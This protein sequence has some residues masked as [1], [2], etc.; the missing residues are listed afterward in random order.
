MS[1]YTPIAT[2]TLGSTASSVIFSSIPQGYTDLVIVTQIKATADTYLNLRFNEDTGSNYSRTT[3]SGSGSTVTSERRSSQSA[4]N[5][6]F[7]ENIQTNLNYTNTLQINNYSNST[8]FKTVICRA[9]NAASGAGA[10]IGLWRNTAAITSISLVANSQL[11]DSGSTFS[12]YGIQAGNRLAKADGGTTVTTD[13]TYWYHTF[14]SSGAFIPKQA[15]TNVDYLVVAGG[16]GGSGANGGADAGNGGGGAGGLRSTITQTGGNSAGVNL[17][18]KLSLSSGVSY[19]VIIGA[20][21]VGGQ[22]GNN[23]TDGTK[24]F[25]SIFSTITSIGGSGGNDYGGSATATGGSGGGAGAGAANRSLGT[26]NQGFDGGTSSGNSG[27][28]GGGAGAVGS[29]AS[30]STGGNGGAGISLAISGSSV[31]YAGGGGGGGKSTGG[32]GGSSVGGAGGSGNNNG[33]AGTFATGS[34]GGGAGGVLSS[35]TNV[36]GTGGS[37]IV[38]IRYAV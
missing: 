3:L 17:E 38:I 34:G 24:G 30:G 12:L 27:G 14:R 20:G 19:P 9:N 2:Q 10:T 18:S 16:G 21:G 5:T 29:N 4:I 28:G 23:T 8:T 31:T 22:G 36:G 1:T 13:G 26:A 33:A 25:D 37:G 6:D 11:F 7:N 35:G 15:L 32:S